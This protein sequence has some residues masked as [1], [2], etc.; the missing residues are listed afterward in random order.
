[1]LDVELG[2]AR[3]DSLGH[4]GC[5]CYSYT[6]HEDIFSISSAYIITGILLNMSRSRCGERAL[7][8]NV[9]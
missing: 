8:W 4:H 7:A 6:G 3:A 9:V 5:A 2:G 1:M